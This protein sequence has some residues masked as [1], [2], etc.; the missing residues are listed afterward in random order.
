MLNDLFSREFG[1]SAVRYY[2][3]TIIEFE[4][5]SQ[6]D[7]SMTNREILCTR[8]IV[9]CSNLVQILKKYDKTEII[10]SISLNLQARKRDKQQ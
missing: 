2:N 6:I 4:D 3:R 7:D 5:N 9:I 8:N 1:S 10:L